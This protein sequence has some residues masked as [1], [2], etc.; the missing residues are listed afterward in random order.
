MTTIDNDNQQQQRM[1]AGAEVNIIG[2]SYKGRKGT[3]HRYTTS[4]KSADIEIDGEIKCL[5]VTSLEIMATSGAESEC[6][7]VNKNEL[8]TLHTDIARLNKNMERLNL[9]YLRMM[10]SGKADREDMA[11][12][13][14]KNM[15]RWHSNMHSNDKKNC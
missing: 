7:Q 14:I 6:V 2:G 8:K 9:N 11:A 4:K 1:E 13:D 5:R 3:F 10:A 15:G 12:D